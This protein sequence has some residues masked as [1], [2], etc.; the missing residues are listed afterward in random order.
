MLKGERRITKFYE[1]MSH[2]NCLAAVYGKLVASR[3]F[4]I[5]SQGDHFKETKKNVFIHCFI[6]LVGRVFA[7]GLGDLGSIQVASH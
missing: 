2:K 4:E 6:G 1:N 3:V 7:N 5:P